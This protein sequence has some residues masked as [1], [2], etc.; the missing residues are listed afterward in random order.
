[1][2]TNTKVQD[3]GD[4]IHNTIV[5]TGVNPSLVYC[6]VTGRPIGKLDDEIFDSF[7][8]EFEGMD[9]EVACDELM[10]RTVCAAR[11]SPLWNSITPERLVTLSETRPAETIAYLLNRLYERDDRFKISQDERVIQYLNR[12]KTYEQ[13]DLLIREGHDLGWWLS[14]LLEVEAKLN[15]RKVPAVGPEMTLFD[16]RF[17]LPKNIESFRELWENWFDE[18]MKAYAI[19]AKQ[20]QTEIRSRRNGGSNMTFL[21]FINDGLMN[22][23]QKSRAERIRAKE[24]KSKPQKSKLRTEKQNFLASLLESIING[25][26]EPVSTVDLP[27]PTPEKTTVVKNGKPV[28]AFKLAAFAKKD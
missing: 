2:L 27:T 23:H 7:L 24:A 15:L 16:E 10:I 13:I 9:L 4:L 1:M 17:V 21:A 18:R 22:P 11:P 20:I 12:I 14:I 5:Q 6:S 8:S 3:L 25:N 28:V 26:L 19:R